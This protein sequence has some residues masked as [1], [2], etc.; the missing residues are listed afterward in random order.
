MAQRCSQLQESCALGAVQ[1]GERRVNEESIQTAKQTL[2]CARQ[3]PGAA[4]PF[5]N[6]D[7]LR[8][9]VTEM[10]K[11]FEGALQAQEAPR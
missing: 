6:P 7:E 2:H 11:G 10:G 3:K 8:R 9:H 4:N 1:F 5:V